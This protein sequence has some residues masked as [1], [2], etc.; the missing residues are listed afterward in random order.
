ML[1]ERLAGDRQIAAQ[2]TPQ[3]KATLKQSNEH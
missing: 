2:S 1:T 3:K